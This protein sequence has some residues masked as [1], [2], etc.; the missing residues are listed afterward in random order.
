MFCMTFCNVNCLTILVLHIFQAIFSYLSPNEYMRKNRAPVG[1]GARFF[2]ELWFVG[3]W[4]S[5]NKGE[6]MDSVNISK[7]S[8]L[9]HALNYLHFPLIIYNAPAHYA[10]ELIT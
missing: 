1:N 9:F 6:R 7:G 4:I 8:N 3:S 5:D 10:S 2:R